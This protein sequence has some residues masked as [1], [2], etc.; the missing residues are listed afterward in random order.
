MNRPPATPTT[1]TS[2]KR[3]VVLGS[4]GSVG[5]S[6]L[7][8]AA[9]L[10]ERISI[11]GLMAHS[12][13][14]ELAEQCRRFKPAV[15]ILPDRTAFERMDRA[16]FPAETELKFG[17]DAA[18]ALAQ[19]DDADVVVS[20][21]VGAAGLHGTWAAVEAGKTVAL[22]NK[23]TLVVA[24]GL[25]TELAAR[26]NAKLLPVDSEHSA[27][28]QCVAGHPMAHV[29]RVVLTASGGPFRGRM[30][31]ELEQVTPEAAL[32]HPTWVMGPKITIDSATLMNKAL[33]VIEAH[34]LFGLTAEQIDVVVHPESV[35]HS[36]VEFI[37]GSVLA[38]LSPPDM[39]LPIQYAL[40]YPDRV[41][42]PA[43]RLDWATLAQFRF[44]G[45]DRQTFPAL[46][47]GAEVI[48]RGGSCGAVL[49]AANE[50]AVAKFLNREFGFLEIARCVRAVLQ[51]HHY[52][53]SPTLEGLLALD[54]WARQEV[55]RWTPSPPSR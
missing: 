40:T 16:A 26:R 30:A 25:I 8:V 4:T 23:E 37:D 32:K 6:T 10:P 3:V 5:T 38:Q 33:E 7:D 43:K 41:P 51:S 45:V 44:E 49:N 19:N 2:P 17:P 54:G 20:A 11:V 22:A 29:E 50:A 36:F 15:A 1:S 35:I 48:R 47:L 28:Y 31:A 46:D 34:W 21:V 52:D 13:W 9:A 12:R 39:R 18:C 55:A 42:G 14:K 24:G 27:I 53:P